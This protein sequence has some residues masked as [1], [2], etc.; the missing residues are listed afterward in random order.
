M[1]GHKPSVFESRALKIV[2]GPKSEAVKEEWGKL[3]VGELSYLKF[4]SRI[5]EMIK[6]RKTR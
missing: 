5:F 3:R 1:N 6:C 4:S 2:F